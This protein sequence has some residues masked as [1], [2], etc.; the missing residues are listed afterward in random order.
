MVRIRII[1]RHWL[2]GINTFLGLFLGLAVLAPGL[3][4]LGYTGPGRLLYL[5]YSFTCHQLP[6]RSYFLFGPQGLSTYSLG[7]ILAEGADPTNLRIFVGNPRLGYKMALAERNTAIYSAM[8]LG[9]LLFAVVRRRVKGLPVRWYVLLILP[10]FLDGASHMVSEI[11][12]L[13]FRQSNGWLSVL[14]G[15]VLGPVFYRGDTMGS[16]NWLM[17]TLTGALFGLANVWLIYPLLQRGFEEVKQVAEAR[18]VE[19][20]TAQ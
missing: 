4:A 3:M 11:T 10:M 9:G 6:Q 12:G 1:N 14:T 2:L 5:A 13:D 17:R 16:F 18:P 20:A 8:F 7:Q 19:V 15:G